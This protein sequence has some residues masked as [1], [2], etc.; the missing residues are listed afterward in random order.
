VR[1]GVYEELVSI[2]SSGN[3]SE[4]YITLEAILVKQPSLMQN[5]PLSRVE[6]AF[7]RFT[8]R[9]TYEL[10]VLRFGISA[11]PN[12]DSLLSGSTSWEP[13]LI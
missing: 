6:L 3:S 5:M 12:I 7:S 2:N 1:G 13:A 10:K 9:A 4:G 11:L 8:I